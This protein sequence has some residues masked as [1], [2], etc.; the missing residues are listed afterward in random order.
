MLL[1]LCG[2]YQI[3]TLTL[4]LVKP[5]VNK[6]DVGICRIQ[7]P[8]KWANSLVRLATGASITCLYV[9][10]MEAPVASWTSGLPI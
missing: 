5:F 10:V 3:M 6:L 8:F 4:C 9:Q 2:V 7:L 1:F